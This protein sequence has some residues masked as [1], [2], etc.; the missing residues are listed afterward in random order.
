MDTKILLRNIPAIFLAISWLPLSHAADTG[1]T[2]LCSPFMEGKVEPTLLTNMLDAARDGNLYRIDSDTSR[3][4]FC[5]SSKFN[6]VKGD[7]RK[8]RGGLA[9]S[10]ATAES[11][12]EQA[13]I[14]INTA[15]L[16][17][18]GSMVENLIKGERFFDVDKY[19]DILFVSRGFEWSGQNSAT[20]VG[21]LTVHGVTRTVAFDVTLTPVKDTSGRAVI[22]SI[23][24]RKVNRMLVKA[25]TTIHRSQFGMDGMSKL[26][27][28][29][30][31]LCMSVEVVRLSA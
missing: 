3:V 29:S 19:P 23:S 14:V 6:E 17:T 2:E 18:Q 15:S 25:T 10:P 1:E 27:S 22:E 4:G 20:I 12:A 9:L 30:V 28:D 7:F 21:D 13:M 24:G 31:D 11:G 16:D 26:V 5:V 8:V